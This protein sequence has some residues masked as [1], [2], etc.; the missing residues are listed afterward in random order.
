M[1]VQPECPL[2]CGPAVLS[3]ACTFSP[4]AR[5]ADVS[6]HLAGTKDGRAP[7]S[8]RQKATMRR[9]KFSTRM[10]ESHPSFLLHF[11]GS[12]RLSL[13]HASR[14]SLSLWRS[15][16]PNQTMPVMLAPAWT[17]HTRA[18]GLCCSSLFLL[19]EHKQTKRLGGGLALHRIIE[20]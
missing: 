5:D 12:I 9:G 1:P 7:S 18:V 8:K 2:P 14:P 20:R 17:H 3:F 11:L 19:P 10:C 4:R 6:F 16:W 15:L 13:A